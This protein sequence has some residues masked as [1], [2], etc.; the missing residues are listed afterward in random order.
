MEGESCYEEYDGG[1]I[2]FNVTDCIN[3]SLFSQTI[4]CDIYYTTIQP[5]GLKLRSDIKVGYR[6]VLD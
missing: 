6:T 2:V 3:T 1:Y 4:A 5:V